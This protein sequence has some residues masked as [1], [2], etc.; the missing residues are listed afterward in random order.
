MHYLIATFCFMSYLVVDTLS[1]LVT[2]ISRY[3]SIVISRKKEATEKIRVFEYLLL[4][5]ALD[6]IDEYADR[7]T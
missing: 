1:I 7:R 2:R 4:G 3:S 6:W 5:F